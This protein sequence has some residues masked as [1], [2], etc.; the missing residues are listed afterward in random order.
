MSSNVEKPQ[1]SADAAEPATSAGNGG[2]RPYPN[3]PNNN[4]KR[5]R[6]IKPGIA[7]SFTKSLA[8]SSLMTSPRQSVYQ[9]NIAT[10][11]F[12]TTVDTLYNVIA[13]RDYRLGERL[14]VNDLKYVSL[15]AL[16]YRVHAARSLA[17]KFTSV[18]FGKLK[19]CVE[20]VVL[21]DF[22]AKAIESVGYVS[23]PSGIS[24]IPAEL[25]NALLNA[26]SYHVH[27]VALLDKDSRTPPTTGFYA[28]LTAAQRTAMSATDAS[29]YYDTAVCSWVFTR[30][31]SRIARGIKS[32]VLF[33]RV[34]FTKPEGAVEYTIVRKVCD[35]LTCVGLATHAVPDSQAKL[36][37]IYG[38]RVS[39]DVDALTT[40][41]DEK[42]VAYVH[43]S[44]SFALD[45]ETVAH[46]SESIR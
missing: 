37:A 46:V 5:Q 27:P 39:T 26:A 18:S 23:L 2:K 11:Y 30:Y 35:G 16:V 24:L 25:T 36:G 15:C 9:I 33:R 6:F 8:P 7:P 20:N 29:V 3:K 41:A 4:N 17:G 10:K 43:T 34:D 42:F 31:M 28:D 13:D 14:T 1:A 32:G 19:E 22:I 44:R 38:Y 45:V 21:P 12:I 40:D